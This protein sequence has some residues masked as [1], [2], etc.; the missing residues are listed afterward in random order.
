MRTSK[1]KHKEPRTRFD[2]IFDTINA[3][4]IALVVLACAYP[5]YYTIV[6]SFSD[7]DAVIGGKVYLWPVKPTLDT[8][9]SV[10][11][12]SSIWVGY[13]NTL[14][15]TVVG[16]IYNLLLLLPASYAL[17]RPTL[18][19][20]GIIMGFFV[21][22]MYFG[23]GTIPFYLQMKS[24]GF[25]DNVLVMIVPGAF[26]VYN[27][28]ITRTYFQSFPE[29]LREAAI[30]DGAS[31][32]R[33]FTQIIIPLSDSIIAVMALYHAVGHWNSYMGALLYLNSSEKYPLQLIM[34]QV[35]LQNTSISLDVTG[36][37]PEELADI[38][39][40][41][42]LAHTMKYSLII[43]ANLP[44]MVAYPFVQRY[45]VKGVMIGAIKG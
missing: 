40:R 8:Y 45:F 15:Y 42:K 31:E 4:L 2:V 12:Y 26:S 29:T 7:P 10:L 3:V 17:S 5:I 35:L 14:F 13:R 36:M 27:M 33:V 34:R 24:M 21:F 6:A 39:R 25:I 18:K 43:V 11:H 22:T 41:T 23:G 19:G 44:V 37:D 28:I 32:F 1:M 20:R 16:T 38:A 9:R 30:I